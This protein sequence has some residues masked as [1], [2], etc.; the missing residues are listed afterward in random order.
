M[1]WQSWPGPWFISRLE[2]VSQSRQMFT[3]GYTRPLQDIQ[4]SSTGY[5]TV[6]P[7]EWFSRVGRIRFRFHWS[8]WFCLSFTEKQ[9]NTFEFTDCFDV[10]VAAALNIWSIWWMTRKGCD[11]VGNQFQELLSCRLQHSPIFLLNKWEVRTCL[12]CWSWVDC[13][14]EGILIRY[15]LHIHNV[16]KVCVNVYGHQRLYDKDI[17]KDEAP[18]PFMLAARCEF[19]IF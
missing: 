8:A 11:T 19:F 12:Q 16:Q 5:L 2:S 4:A 14:I 18:E 17:Y 3:P 7:F 13:K 9:L 1:N 6:E 15:T 10:V